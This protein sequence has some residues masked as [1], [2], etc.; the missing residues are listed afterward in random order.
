MDF[1]KIIPELLKANR[2]RLILLSLILGLTLRILDIKHVVPPKYQWML[3]GSEIFCWIGFVVLV[4]ASLWVRKEQAEKGKKIK[5]T[6]PMPHSHLWSQNKQHDGSVITQVAAQIQV[7]NR[8]DKYLGLS[9]V[10][11]VNPKIKGEVS[12]NQIYLKSPISGMSETLHGSGAEIPP[13]NSRPCSFCL[14]IEGNKNY[15]KGKIVKAK[16]GITD[17]D[18]IEEIFVINFKVS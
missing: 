9:T 18:G 8:T 12:N 14:L 6:L 2:M 13:Y 5:I 1:I 7:K 3:Y 17:D 4:L 10:R 15:P 11:L 16:V